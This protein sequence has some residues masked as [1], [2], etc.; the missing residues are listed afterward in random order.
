V[1]GGPYHYV[2]HPAYAGTILYELAASFLLA[3]WPALIAS[4]LSAALLILRTA[5]ED[6]MLRT[7]LP[8]YLEYAQHVRYRLFPDLW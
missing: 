8:G 7:E 4:G 2:R 6:R 1:T 5:L 3:S